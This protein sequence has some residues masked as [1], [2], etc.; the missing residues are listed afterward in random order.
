MIRVGRKKV[1]ASQAGT[2]NVK[3]NRESK[4]IENA[5]EVREMK[6]S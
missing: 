6:G 1:Q 2:Y 4:D 5:E 3:E